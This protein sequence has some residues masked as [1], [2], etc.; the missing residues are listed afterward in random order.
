MREVWSRD[1]LLGTRRDDWIFDPSDAAAI[2]KRLARARS[3]RVR[4][5][6]PEPLAP[7]D[8]QPPATNHQPPPAVY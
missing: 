3:Q 6:R 2:R 5:A 4:E 1:E 8:H 7:P